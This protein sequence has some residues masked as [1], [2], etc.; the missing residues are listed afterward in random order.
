MNSEVSISE[1]E[2]PAQSPFG[3]ILDRLAQ[4]HFI[5]TVSDDDIGRCYDKCEL[6]ETTGESKTESNLRGSEQV[7]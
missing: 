3:C 1:S 4:P 2:S 5:G 7:G 6:I